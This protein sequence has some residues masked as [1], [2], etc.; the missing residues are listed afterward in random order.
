MGK[1]AEAPGLQAGRR[2]RTPGSRGEARA[3]AVRRR[4]VEWEGPRR[5]PGSR[6]WGGGAPRACA[7]RASAS[8]LPLRPASPGCLQVAP[9]SSAAGRAA[10]AAYPA[11][12]AVRSRP[13]PQ[14]AGVVFDFS[15]RPRRRGKRRA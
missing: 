13:G 10:A 3:G 1:Q 9:P 4:G 14:L 15:A 2:T 12:V 7:E 5:L 6:R 11:A 8:L